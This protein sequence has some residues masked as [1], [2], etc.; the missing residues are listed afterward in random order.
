[1]DSAR[2]PSYVAP[3]VADMT[4]N[5]RRIA[6]ARL[7]RRDG[8]TYDEIRA[9]VGP[10]SD[11]RLQ[12]WLAGIPRPSATF[13]GRALDDVRREC[14]RLRAQGLTYDEIAAKTGASKG[15]LSLWLRGQVS[16]ARERYDQREHLRRIRPM[17]VA[18]HRRRAL[19]RSARARA[20]GESAVGVL[21][22][23]DLFM[24]GLALYWAEGSKDKPWRRNGRVILIN[25]DPGVLHAF[26][27]WLDL[28][29]IAEEDRSYRLN[30]HESADV[31][32][33]EQWWA[34]ELRVPLA[35]FGRATLK[36][37]TPATVRHNVGDHYH[38]CLVV[39]IRRSRQ[40]YDAIDGGWRRIVDATRPM[41]TQS[42]DGPP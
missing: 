15:S 21:T 31:T 32:R 41:S 4:E 17:A 7:L 12:A 27:A 28:M 33:H 8:K 19:E 5:Q 34:E 37:H 26:L 16:P 22:E 13:R 30:I 29:G 23:R 38:G 18:E 20:S 42:H 35:S 25:S 40:L 14:R 1:M 9:V 10:V 39:S 6:R 2:I 36:G 3:I 24:V 11:D